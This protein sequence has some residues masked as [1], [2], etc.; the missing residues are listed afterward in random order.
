MRKG[1]LLGMV[2]L[3][4]ATFTVVA[5]L[6]TAFARPPKIATTRCINHDTYFCE[7][8]GFNPIA[9]VCTWQSTGCELN[10]NCWCETFGTDEYLICEYYGGYRDTIYHPEGCP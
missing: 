5:V 9:E 1:L 4:V 2:V 3:L 10:H 7:I 6:T 8:V